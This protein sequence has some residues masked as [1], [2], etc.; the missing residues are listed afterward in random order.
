MS[1][2]HMR[3]TQYSD[4]S[5]YG[6]MIAVAPL[7]E[8]LQTR[9]LAGNVRMKHIDLQSNLMRTLDFGKQPDCIVAR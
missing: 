9:L 8:I 6:C 2:A 1:I 5:V 3:L 4:G 7:D